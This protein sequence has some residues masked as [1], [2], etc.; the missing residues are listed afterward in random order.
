[1]PD[2]AMR[3]F[4]LKLASYVSDGVIDAAQAASIADQIGI[5]FQDKVIGIKLQGQLQ[6]L[7]TV[8]GKDLATEP[9]EIRIK[10]A[11]ETIDQFTNIAPNLK[12][13]LALAQKELNSGK[14]DAAFNI[15]PDIYAGMNASPAEL[16][17]AQQ[18]QEKAKQAQEEALD[19]YNKAK[20][21]IDAINA[22][23][24]KYNAF[25]GAMASQSF[26]SIQA[27]IDAIDVIISKTIDKLKVDK[28]A[29]KDLAKQALI[30]KEIDRLETKKFD[31]TKKLRNMNNQVTRGIQEQLKL[32][33]PG[34]RKQF[35]LASSEAIKTRFKGTKQETDANAFL[36]RSKAMGET[37]LR[38]KI[39]A[40]VSSGQ[41]GNSQATKL[42]NFF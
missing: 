12:A 2:I 14:F 17:A 37:S 41:L 35:F 1:M 6:K 38:A 28:A 9:F 20:E 42:L 30:Q 36:D 13:Q 15:V 5:Q 23:L 33:N 19:G 21:K 26:E 18:K 40:V 34:E 27:Q 10:I 8:D 32:A 24:G 16:A 7:L 29:T 25:A 3:E 22:S 31:S 11:Q 4:S 39:E